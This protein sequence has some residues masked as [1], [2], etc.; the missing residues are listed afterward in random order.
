MKMNSYL[1]KNKKINKSIKNNL[2]TFK[3]CKKLFNKN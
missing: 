3:I 1:N 2:A